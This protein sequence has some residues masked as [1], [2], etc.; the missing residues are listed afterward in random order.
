MFLFLKHVNLYPDYKF[1]KFIRSLL[2]NCRKTIGL[3]SEVSKWN[4]RLTHGDH[5]SFQIGRFQMIFMEL[6]AMGLQA[7]E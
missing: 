6:R 3:F 5:A 4:T 2:S 1:V 7:L